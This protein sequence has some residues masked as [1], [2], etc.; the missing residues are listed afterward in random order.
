M[1]DVSVEFGP[2]RALAPRYDGI[3][4]KPSYV[5]VG[6]LVFTHFSTPLF[7]QAAQGSGGL[8]ALI[9][10]GPALNIPQSVLS[11]AMYR[12][13]KAEMGDDGLV[14]LLRVLKHS[15]NAGY[16]LDAVRILRRVNGKNVSGLA[17][18]LENLCAVRTAGERFLYFSF[19][20]DDVEVPR[21]TPEDP[22]VVLETDAIVAADV[23]ILARNGIH[24]RVSQDLS[25]SVCA[26]ELQEHHVTSK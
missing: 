5:I 21:E 24:H 3:D 6:G 9:G 8:A 1:G 18:L 12:W 13:R 17:G 19:A 14:V 16:D 20:E 11:E 23:E 10:G 25:S 4:A 7:N 22:D 15:V 26:D 2:L